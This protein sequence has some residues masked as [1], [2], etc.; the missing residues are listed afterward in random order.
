MDDRG[1][2]DDVER[3]ADIVIGDEHADAAIFQMRD[4]GA[5]VAD[6]DG[7]DAREGLVEQDVGRA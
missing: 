7:V 4:E 1:A 2:V 3:L 5:D 6:R